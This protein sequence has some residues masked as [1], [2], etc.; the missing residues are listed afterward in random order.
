MVAEDLSQEHAWQVSQEFR[1]ASKFSGPLNF[2][3]GGNYMHYET[4]EDYYVFFNLLSAISQLQDG[5]DAGQYTQCL[6]GIDPS[7]NQGIPPFT[8][9]PE[10]FVLNLLG[11]PVAWTPPACVSFVLN[12]KVPALY[13]D[14]NP[15]NR[16]NGLGHNYFRSEN[17]YDL[18]SYAGFSEAYYQIMPDLKPDLAGLRWTDDQKTFWNI[19]SWVFEAGGGYPVESVVHQEWKEWTGR[20]VANWTPKLDFT[21]QTLIYASYARGYKGGGA[22]PPGPIT[23]FAS[24]QSSVTHP[25]TF[26]PEFINAYELGTEKE[27]V[28]RWSAYAEW[29]CLLL[30]LH[31]LSDFADC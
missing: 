28:A 25:P 13:I 4:V 8:I 14:P 22:N 1:L 11:H 10:P 2:S 9:S 17:P 6:S 18:N 5:Q 30:R 16:I 19:P 29:R 27:H 26:A 3:V 12:G 21:D 31:R 15:L 20:F 7:L 23:D 24:A